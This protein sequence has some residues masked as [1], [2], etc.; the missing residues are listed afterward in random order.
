MGAK[1]I[2][3]RQAKEH[4]DIHKAF[5]RKDWDICVSL[6]AECNKLK[7][8]ID[9]LEGKHK[10]AEEQ[11]AEYEKAMTETG[12]STKQADIELNRLGDMLADAEALFG[13]ADAEYSG[14]MVELKEAQTN[15]ALYQR[16][17]AELEEEG[18]RANLSN[19]VE[20]QAKALAVITEYNGRVV[21]EYNDLKGHFKWKRWTQL[22]NCAFNLMKYQKA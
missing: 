21:K 11:Q 14:H 8:Q 18:C 4:G 13:G 17:L 19:Y 5:E 15:F 2:R 22:K 7:W 20:K 6:S 3:D 9:E 10:S 16:Q 12:M 1:E